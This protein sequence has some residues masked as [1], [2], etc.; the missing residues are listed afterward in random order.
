MSRLAVLL[1]LPLWLFSALAQVDLDLVL[2]REV[3]LP[4]EDIEIGVRIANFTGAKATFGQESNWLQF[5]VEG[6]RGRVVSKLQDPPESG[7]F[8]LEQS[9][10][11]K[12]RYNLTPLFSME[13]PGNY[14]VFATLRLP[15]GEVISSDSKN[16][17]IV[18]GVKLSE[19]REVGYTLPDG[20]IERRKFMLQRATFLKKVQL[21]ARLTDSSESHTYKVIPLGNTVSFDR[22]EWL[23]DRG[24]RFHVLHRADSTR[25]F[26][27]I[28][29]PD[30]TIASRQLWISNG[31]ARPELRVNEEG[32]IRVFRATRESYP[33]DIPK[34]AD[35]VT[36]TNSPTATQLKTNAA[37][38]VQAPK[39]P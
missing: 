12:L 13:I 30:G 6:D 2:E 31:T 34:P 36:K 38:E 39:K 22:P 1:S 27:H 10:R 4:A 21:Y 9:T 5:M 8:T 20:T 24:T 26:Y 25:Y 23:A 18:Q 15:S 19:P 7:E 16:I 32:E 28:L 35:G 14:R 33:G 29:S 3:F 11:G 17:E 37:H